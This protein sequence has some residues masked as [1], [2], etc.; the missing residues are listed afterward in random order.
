MRKNL[1][2]YVIVFLCVALAASSL[3]SAHTRAAVVADTDRSAKAAD[4]S[5][6]TLTIQRLL[7]SRLEWTRQLV[8]ALRFLDLP[9]TPPG[10][11]TNTIIDEPDPAGYG[12]NPGSEERESDDA[13][14]PTD[15]DDNE[16]PHA[17]QAG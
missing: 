3:A 8:R 11:G 14:P 9:P 6:G 2:C 15:V 12:D 17:V 5:Q 4:V 1:A 16:T 7:Q 10:N 13:D